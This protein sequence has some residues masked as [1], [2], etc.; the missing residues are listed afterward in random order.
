MAT[1]LTAE[2]LTED[3]MA[4]RWKKFNRERLH[5]LI[6]WMSEPVIAAQPKRGAIRLYSCTTRHQK[7]HGGRLGRV[8]MQ[9]VVGSSPIIRS[10]YAGQ[11]RKRQTSV[12]A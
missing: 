3:E 11:V 9:K 12:P 4:E 1:L 6:L 7:E 8:A 2:E 5:T 10:C